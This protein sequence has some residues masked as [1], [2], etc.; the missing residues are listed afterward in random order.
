MRFDV[1]VVGTKTIGVMSKAGALCL[2]VD[3]GQCLLIDGEEVTCAA[4]AS[5]IAIVADMQSQE[6][7]K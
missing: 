5:G 4:D 3:A 1:P 7:A 2:A 6:N